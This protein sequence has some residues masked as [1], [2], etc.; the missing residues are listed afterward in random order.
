MVLPA[1]SSRGEGAALDVRTRHGGDSPVPTSERRRYF[2]SRGR[3]RSKA[4][5]HATRGFLR[6]AV[7]LDGS[8]ELFVKRSSLDHRYGTYELVA[9]VRE[10]ARA[11]ASEFPASVLTVGDI[12]R[13][14]GGR[15]RP[16]RSHRR[17]LDADLGFFVVDA[18]G[19]PIESRTFV[20][21][22]SEG[23]DVTGSGI[24]FD[25][26][27]NWALVTALLRQPHASVQY[28]IVARPLEALLLEHA[29]TIGAPA[30]LIAAAATV[31]YQPSRGGAHDN[32]FHVRFY[33]AADDRPS[34]VDA[35][36]FH[37][38][39]DRAGVLGRE[40]TPAQDEAKP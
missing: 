8:L 40:A 31:L 6:N 37:P 15:I 19:A 35:P 7:A 5:G 22:N 23:F 32:H 14:A 38:W 26:A 11:V 39:F 4:I 13:R 3:S 10:A 2:D 9:A 21:M 33:C 12:S 27:R 24:R 16:H 20:R 1:S 30:E 29:V 36:P 17:G 25:V 34:C 18:E 28:L